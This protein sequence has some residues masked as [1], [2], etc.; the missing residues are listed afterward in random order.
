VPLAPQ[1][2]DIFLELF[3]VAWMPHYLLKVGEE[4]QEIPAFKREV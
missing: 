2:K 3:G 4:T 1:K